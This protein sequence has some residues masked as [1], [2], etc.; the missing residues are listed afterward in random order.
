[1]PQQAEPGLH[2]RGQKEHPAQHVGARLLRRGPKPELRLLFREV[3]QD[4]ADSRARSAQ[5]YLA[6]GYSL[7]DIAVG[8]G[9]ENCEA[10]GVTLDGYPHLH[11]WRER[12]R[13]RPAWQEKRA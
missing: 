13:Q 6:G 10:R 8:C 4:R 1:M 2:V 7:A 5:E 9:L 3:N 12:L 11:A